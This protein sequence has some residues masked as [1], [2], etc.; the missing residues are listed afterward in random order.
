MSIRETISK[1][2]KTQ[3]PQVLME[4]V[5]YARALG[6][7]MSLQ[8]GT[9]VGQLDFDQHLIG[10][11]GAATLHGGTIGSLLETTAIFTL[12][13]EIEKTLMPK[14][15]NLTVEHLQPG[16]PKTT[17]ARAEI[18]RHGRRVANVRVIAWQDDPDT[19]IAAAYA[20]FLLVPTP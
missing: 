10:D 1:A 5:P 20:H 12:L 9:L 18:T 15:I 7:G 3:E 6:I 17:F 14:T 13:W 8:N 4:H 16:R 19:P 2:R 11:L